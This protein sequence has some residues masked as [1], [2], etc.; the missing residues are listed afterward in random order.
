MNAKQDADEAIIISQAGKLGSVTIAT[1]MAGR[2][3]DIKVEEAAIK[4]KGE[5]DIVCGT[6]TY[7]YELGGLFVIGTEKHETRRIDNQLRGRSGRQGDP[8]ISQFFVAPTDDIMR[9]FGGEKLFSI[10]NSGMFASLPANEP[11][12]QS[13]MLTSRITGVQ[14]Q[15]EGRNF[16]V[17]KHILEYDDVLNQHRLVMY[18]RR[19]RILEQET[20]HEEVETAFSRVIR[21]V[22]EKY[23]FESDS[24]T[25]L[26]EL[27]EEVGVLSGINIHFE[28]L[29]SIEEES[30]ILYIEKQFLAPVDAL[31]EKVGE[32]EFTRFEKQLLLGSI[33]ELWMSHIDRMAHLREE[34]A[35]EGYAQKQPL[36]VYKE[37]AYERFTELISTIDYRLV[38]GLVSAKDILDLAQK[39]VEENTLILGRD[40]ASFEVELMQLANDAESAAK[41]STEPGQQIS[42]TQKEDGIRVIRMP[43][44][45]TRSP[46]LAD[47][48]I[49]F[50]NIKRNDACPCGS[51]KK[52]KQCHGKKIS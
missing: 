23:D 49:D 33:D 48:L 8:G 13:G 43:V 17:R 51:G 22:V 12:A 36:I 42:Q 21:G 32:E 2:G 52:F 26:K 4:L 44:Q 28:D 39:E 24:A 19:N 5:V 10:F 34:V 30:I 3:T 7:T 1:N 41:N 25:A 14:K 18:G 46:D 37:R 35:F 29:T 47:S 9:I 31:K 40:S 50:S 6:G 15:V 45:S 16:D 38:K 27:S 11:L 20:V